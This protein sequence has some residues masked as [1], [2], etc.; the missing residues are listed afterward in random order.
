MISVGMLVLV[1]VICFSRVYLGVHYL[2]DVLGGAAAGATWLA[3][4][5]VVHAAYSERFVAYFAG[6]HADRF[7]RR[8]TRS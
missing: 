4:S 1:V 3:F 8:L 6:S 5:I 2:S 7:L